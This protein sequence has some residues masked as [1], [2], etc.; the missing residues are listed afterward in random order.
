MTSNE[1]YTV[2]CTMDAEH[3][4]FF[5]ILNRL[6]GAMTTGQGKS[7]QA[8]ILAEIVACREV[9]GVVAHRLISGKLGGD[10][11]C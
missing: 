1:Q 3:K 10:E 11:T 9:R 5:H 8:G 2:G 7:V 6:H 4:I